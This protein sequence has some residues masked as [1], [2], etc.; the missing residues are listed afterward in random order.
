MSNPIRPSDPSPISE[1]LLKNTELN[2]NSTVVKIGDKSYEVV[3]L[4]LTTN[5]SRSKETSKVPITQSL[6][7]NIEAIVRYTIHV[8][9]VFDP[10]KEIEIGDFRIILKTAASNRLRGPRQILEDLG[11]LIG[12]ALGIASSI[13]AQPSGA[14]PQRALPRQQSQPASPPRQQPQSSAN[15]NPQGQ[16]IQ[17]VIKNPSELNTPKT[18][19]FVLTQLLEFHEKKGCPSQKISQRLVLLHTAIEAAGGIGEDTQKAL[20][21]LSKDCPNSKNVFGSSSTINGDPLKALQHEIHEVYK[22]ANP[23]SRNISADFGKYALT[24]GLS[25]PELSG[26]YQGYIMKALNVL[27]NKA[28][29]ESDRIEAAIH[30]A[31]QSPSDNSNQE[32]AAICA[33]LL[34]TPTDSRQ[35][36]LAQASRGQAPPAAAAAP[37]TPLATGEI[38]RSDPPGSLIIQSPP[39]GDCAAH[40]IVN[41]LQQRN[42]LKAD[43]RRFTDQREVRSL[44]STKLERIAETLANASGDTPDSA[45]ADQIIISIQEAY[46]KIDRQPPSLRPTLQSI[47]TLIEK[48]KD[49]RGQLSSAEKKTLLQAY[50]KC[51]N[52]PNFWLDVGFFGIV[53]KALDKQIV[54]LTQG[55]NP[56]LLPTIS[57]KFPDKEINVDSALFIHF[58][59]TQ[60]TAGNHYDSIS[61]AHTDKLSTL[62]KK[63]NEAKIDTFISEI[64]AQKNKKNDFRDK[65]SAVLAQLD[66]IKDSYPTAFQ[67]ISDLI[68]EKYQ[69]SNPESEMTEKNWLEIALTLTKAEIQTK[70]ASMAKKTP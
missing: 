39:D 18:R 3:V 59:A 11:R 64:N 14:S 24:E 55:S 26:I 46:E 40:S 50:A 51:I 35:D 27:I 54:V 9:K 16:I 5:T 49:P 41:Q 43:G 62:V 44:A 53:A 52:T 66:Q 65:I 69:P 67:A 57:S 61:T 37:A 42:I 33:D 6:A 29:N 58:N 60:F 22:K 28:N 68:A 7:K 21:Q 4:K 19:E 36:S 2:P 30:N 34:K 45:L 48:S 13:R 56:S 47:T 38:R 20:L 17:N 10:N 70:I 23:G 25:N 31:L 12:K 32:I 8:N 1:H 15:T 63:D